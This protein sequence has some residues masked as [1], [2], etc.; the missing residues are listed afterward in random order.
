M[1]GG[2]GFEKKLLLKVLYLLRVKILFP[3]VDGEDLEVVA[4]IGAVLWP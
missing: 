3:A 1:R 2:I 4:V